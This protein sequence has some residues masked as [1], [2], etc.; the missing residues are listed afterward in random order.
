VFIENIKYFLYKMDLSRERSFE[1]A[2]EEE[3]DEMLLYL[4]VTEKFKKQKKNKE[5]MG[6]KDISRKRKTRCLLNSHL[7]SP[8]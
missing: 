1:E 6:S 5:N 8:P 3:D 7:N 2:C 4:L